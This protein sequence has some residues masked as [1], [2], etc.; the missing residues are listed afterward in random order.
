MTTEITA[1]PI[2]DEL[3]SNLFLLFLTNACDSPTELAE[4][5][6]IT[7]D[8]V[9]KIYN[10]EVFPTKGMVDKICEVLKLDYEVMRSANILVRSYAKNGGKFK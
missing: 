2:P 5:L 4:K 9:R 8:T 3:P 1:M 7:Y 10:G 6:E